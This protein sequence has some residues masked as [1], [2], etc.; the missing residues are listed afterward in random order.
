[1]IDFVSVLGNNIELYADDYYV[2]MSANPE[3]LAQLILL[4]GGLA[5]T[6]YRSSDWIEH[7]NCE[8][9]DAVWYKVCKL[10]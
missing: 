7:P 2:G 5:P 8:E 1:M 3:K 10:V 9:F 6:V 4:H